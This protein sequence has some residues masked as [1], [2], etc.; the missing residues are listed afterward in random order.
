MKRYYPYAVDVKFAPLWIPFG[1]R[2]KKDGVTI[3]DNDIFMA[4]FGFL[5]L[6]TSLDNVTGAHITR[7]YRWWTAIGA[8]TSFADDGLSFGTNTKAGVCVHFA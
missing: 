3:T 8:R 5:R 1:V 6:E 2:P 4:T 7:D